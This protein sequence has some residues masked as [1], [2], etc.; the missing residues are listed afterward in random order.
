MGSDGL[1]IVSQTNWSLLM[2][3]RSRVLSAL[4]VEEA[5]Y[6]RNLRSEITPQKVLEVLSSLTISQSMSGKLSVQVLVH[7]D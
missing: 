3:I 5:I 6:C 4:L 2:S 7:P 1:I